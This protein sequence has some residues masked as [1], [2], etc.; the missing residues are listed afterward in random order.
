[1]S[2][3]KRDGDARTVYIVE[4]VHGNGRATILG[5]KGQG[6]GSRL[7]IGFC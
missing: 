7:N 6:E 4:E 5:E 1:M 2:V 3:V